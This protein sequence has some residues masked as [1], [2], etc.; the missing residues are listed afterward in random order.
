MPGDQYASYFTSLEHGG[1]RFRLFWLACGTQD[2]VIAS[3]RKFE[4]WLKEKRVTFSS[5]ET[6]GAHTWMVWRRFLTELAPLLFREG[7]A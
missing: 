3:H 6:S 2:R 7:K 1:P 4:K 5:K